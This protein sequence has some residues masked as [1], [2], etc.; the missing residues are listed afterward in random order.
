MMNCMKMLAEDGFALTKEGKF[1]K[2]KEDS[3][4]FISHWQ[5]TAR[6]IA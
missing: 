6:K 1:R 5:N 2:L 4:E 3:D